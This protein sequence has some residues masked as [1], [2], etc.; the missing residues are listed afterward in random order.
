MHI[1]ISSIWV[2]CG[3]VVGLRQLMDAIISKEPFDFEF[4]KSEIIDGLDQLK[5]NCGTEGLFNPML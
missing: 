5:K 4:F 3:V 1:L 2:N